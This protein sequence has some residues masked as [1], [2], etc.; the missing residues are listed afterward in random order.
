M[1][2]VIFPLFFASSALY[3]LWRVRESSPLLYKICFF[4]PFTHAVELIRFALYGQVNFQALAVVVGCTALFL[5]AAIL[6]LRSDPRLHRP[7]RR[8]GRRRGVAMIGRVAA[9]TFGLV[10]LAAPAVAAAATTEPASTWPC[11]Q[12]KV[13]ELS[14]GGIWQRGDLADGAAKLSTDPAVQTLA[15]KLAARRTAMDE[16]ASDIKAFAKTAGADERPDAA[17][18]VPGAVRPDAGRTQPGDGR[19]RALWPP[20]ARPGGQGQ[21]RAARARPHAGRSQGRSGQAR[22]RR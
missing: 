5:G 9:L 15:E 4:N 6:G 1:N 12:R 19:H 11:I 22:H 8:S 2:F 21:G 16:A 3:P 13:P 10:V 20:P 18:A 17:G 7:A 14:L